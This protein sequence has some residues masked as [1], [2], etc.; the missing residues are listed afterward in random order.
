MNN[1][2]SK[3]ISEIMQYF[4]VIFFPIA[5]YNFYQYIGFNLSLSKAIYF[6]LVLVSFLLVISELLKKHKSFR[7]SN[8]M[9]FLLFYMFFSIFISYIS[10]D[11]DI[12]MGYRSIA[13]HLAIIY[14]FILLKIRIP[15]EK[16]EKIIWILAILYIIL[17]IFAIIKA[18]E[19]VFGIDDEAEINDNRGFF[20]LN[21]PGGG[22]IIFAFFLALNKYNES[23]KLFW[24]AI[25]VGLFIIIVMHVIRQIIFFTF[26]LGIYYL[27]KKNKYLW[28]G[29][30]F[31]GVLMLGISN[32][33]INDDSIF[34]KLV[35]L[36]KDQIE[37]NN[38]GEEDIRIQAYQ[39]F[40]TEYTKKP[41][42]ILFGN[43]VPHI[44]S[45]LGKLEYSIAQNNYLWS[46]DVGFASIYIK[47][48]IIGLILYFL[49]F[50]RVLFQK[51]Q[52]NYFYA[53]L[54]II[55]VFAVTIAAQYIFTDVIIFAMAI[56]VLEYANFETTKKKKLSI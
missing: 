6:L 36:S 20:R 44:E 39:F 3:K 52:P 35:N 48:G 51:L 31:G 8:L 24:I 40:F 29:L 5:S 27:L 4:W 34:G 2:Q 11:Q 16:L 25:F 54:F 56:Y 43:G 38:S 47:Y 19:L 42:N 1:H 30:A 55:Y 26:L 28:F 13:S 46:S 10:W 14:F 37:N 21:I 18:P 7:Y 33:Q 50:R 12:V 32:I 49:I 23:K 15:I 17:W 9:K 45:K 22:I 53:K 41:I